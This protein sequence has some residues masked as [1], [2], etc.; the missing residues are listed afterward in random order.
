MLEF[1]L[2]L[3][4]MLGFRI[5]VCVRGLKLKGLKFTYLDQEASKRAPCVSFSSSSSCAGSHVGKLR[6]CCLPW[7]C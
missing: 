4:F 2:G 5:R 1:G 3:G 6:A 7:M